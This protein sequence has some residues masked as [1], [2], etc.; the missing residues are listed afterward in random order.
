[1]NI[2]FFYKKKFFSIINYIFFLFMISACGYQLSTNI[3]QNEISTTNHKQLTVLLYS[4]DPFNAITRTIKNELI[5]NNIIIFNNLYDIIYPYQK[6]ILP[7]LDIIDVSEKHVVISVFPDGT[8]SEYKII[9]KIKAQFFIPKKENYYPVNIS[10]YRT[11]IRNPELPL[12]NL[13]QDYEILN[14]MYQ[15]IAQKFVQQFLMQLNN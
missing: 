5:L 7:C 3:T 1:M 13:T 14:E 9:L 15:D 2:R 4:Y 11:F 8:T 12:S 6:T 10:I